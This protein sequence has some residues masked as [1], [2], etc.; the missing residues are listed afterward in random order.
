MATWDLN[1]IILLTS[2]VINA[3]LLSMVAFYHLRN[4]R[5]DVL[6]AFFGSGICFMWWFV[7]NY[8]ADAAS[9]V[10]SS[11]FWT[12]LTVL[13][14]LLGLWFFL[15]F[16]SL[17]PTK[18]IKSR[19]RLA[20]YLTAI[21]ILSAAAL[22]SSLVFSS[23]ELIR[24]IGVTNIASGILYPVMIV[25]Y[26][27]LMVDI[28]WNL[29]RDYR[30][31]AG[32]KKSQ[33]KYLISGWAIFLIGGA[34]VSLVLP[35]LTSNASI[36]KFGPL[37]SIPMVGLTAYA[38]I[39]HQ[40][41]DIRLVMQRG[42]IYS[43]L[44]TLIIIAYLSILFGV[45]AMLV[46]DIDN[47][48]VVSA[49]IVTVIGIFGVP[50]LDNYL[51][52]LTD[53]WFFKN[54]YDYAEALQSIS[55][56]L[57]NNLNLE[58][59]MKEISRNIKA[60]F[61]INHVALVIQEQLVLFRN[62][63][64]MQ[65]RYPALAHFLFGMLKEENSIIFSEEVEQLLIEKNGGSVLT[66]WKS[67]INERGLEIFVRIATSE[68]LTGFLCLGRKPSGEDYTY[69]DQQLLNTFANHAAVAIEKAILYERL[70]QQAGQLEQKVRQRTAELEDL[71][72]SQNQI[73]I[74]ISHSLQTPLTIMKSELGSLEAAIPAD[75]SLK[76]LEKT[77]DEISKR[78]YDLLRLARMESQES[79]F[80][81]E[82][83]DLSAV[84]EELSEYI[85][86]LCQQQDI[87]LVCD[88]E[89]G[90]FVLGDRQHL[91]EM[92]NNLISNSIKYIANDRRIGI[93]LRRA[94]SSATI[95]VRDSGVGIP[96]ESLARIFD[97]FY[98][99]PSNYKSNGMGV[100]L[101]I[102]KKIAEKHGGKISTESQIG[103]GSSFTISLPLA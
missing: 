70:K 72:E 64:P 98:R 92:V 73:F 86:V 46:N 45:N 82:R 87:H 57:N 63:Y 33:V 31:V 28:F 2:L 89:P 1:L 97:R 68:K 80:R 81:M 85:S 103:K 42:A 52:R 65:L 16:C 22:G 17:F 40:L 49:A 67:L 21:I 23:V 7:T 83:V 27:L 37:F 47:A 39:R 32:Q 4:L 101:A 61:K 5:Q 36:S 48:A 24:G 56:S 84:L 54:N 30:A 3:A 51:R 25:L 58:N 9:T 59:L 11:L 41:L 44:F 88:I 62:G 75:D 13:P 8:L 26:L 55:K 19:S 53:R 78:I 100:G 29:A 96:P 77:V 12:R 14:S 38:I 91:E 50:P 34:A 43:A 76:N 99:A 95:T 69:Q 35:Y 10:G 15:W 20:V 60:I 66:D 93:D 6:A 79:A 71:Q 74:D 94:D 90:I 102:T 18:K